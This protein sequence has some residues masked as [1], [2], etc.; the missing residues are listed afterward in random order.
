MRVGEEMMREPS[1]PDRKGSLLS[2]WFFE[3]VFDFSFFSEKVFE[4]H[5]VSGRGRTVKL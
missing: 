3:F 1:F 5:S 4:G 2:A